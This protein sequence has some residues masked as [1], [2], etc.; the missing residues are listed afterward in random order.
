MILSIVMNM[1]IR[2]ICKLDNLHK[3]PF[4][5]SPWNKLCLIL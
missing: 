5:E 1:Q 4:G 3:L 2:R